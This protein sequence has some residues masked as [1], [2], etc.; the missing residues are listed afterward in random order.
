LI[1][2]NGPVVYQY[3]LLTGIV[4]SATVGTEDVFGSVGLQINF[5]TNYLTPDLAIRIGKFPSWMRIAGSNSGILNP[6]QCQNVSLEFRGTGLAPGI[7]TGQ[8]ALQSND[9]DEN[10]TLIPV[11]Y[12]IGA[13]T[14]PDSVTISYALTAGTTTLRWPAAGAPFYKIYSAATLGGPFTQLEGST[15][16]TSLTVTAAA[17]SRK[18]FVVIASDSP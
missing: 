9:A 12:L 1:Y 3:K 2:R 15:S 13:L 5:N 6:G 7:Y 11:T 10:P 4:N 14:A 8:L 18:Y 17:S 16:S